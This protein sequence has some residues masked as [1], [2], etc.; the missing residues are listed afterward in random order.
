VYPP[1]QFSPWNAPALRVGGAAG[2]AAAAGAA[3]SG[4]ATTGA[5]ATGAAGA[6]AAGAGAAT[7]AAA[8]GAA[9]TGA[10][11][12]G[13]AGASRLGAPPDLDSTAPGLEHRGHD[14]PG[15]GY[16]DAAGPGYHDEAEPGYSGRVVSDPAAD[17]IATETWDAVEDSG[18]SGGWAASAGPGGPDAPTGPLAARGPAVPSGPAARGPA[19]PS[20]PAARGHP[21]AADLDLGRDRDSDPDD[22]SWYGILAGRGAL[23]AAGA[24]GAAAAGAAGAASAD[25]L[26]GPR[27]GPPPS[28]PRPT[29]SRPAGRGGPPGKP[30]RRAR[31]WLMPLVMLLIA[32]GLVTWAYLHFVKGGANAAS[33]AAP[34]RTA[35]PS[36]HPAPT[37]GPWKYI[38]TRANDPAALT[39]TELFPAQFSSGGTVAMRTIQDDGTNCVKMVIGKSLQTALRKAGCTQ[40]LRASYLSTGQKIMATIGVLNLDDVGGAQQAGKATGSTAFIKQLPAA[41][42]PTKHLAQGTGLEEAQFKGHYLILTWAEFTN[43]KAP[44]SAKQRAELDAF[45]R[46]LVAGTANISLTSRELF[47]RPQLPGH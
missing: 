16:H 3:G 11:A 17:A 12:A 24:A 29:S 45:S 10:A 2:R 26:S 6:G 35:S 30:G 42:G 33:P 14:E 43:L 20:G 41:H 7:G 5:A 25:E 28:G 15:P 31:I 44:G 27:A 36:S 1:G 8:T 19:V 47:G 39:L 37:L 38:S 32:G 46:N 9:A 40:V 4:A 13:A 21:A 18:A 34:A 23:P 22:T